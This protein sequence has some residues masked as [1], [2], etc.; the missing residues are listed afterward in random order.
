M[1]AM[2]EEKNANR[3]DLFEVYTSAK[4]KVDAETL[5]HQSADIPFPFLVMDPA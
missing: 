4:G 3:V 5:N 2:A 1:D